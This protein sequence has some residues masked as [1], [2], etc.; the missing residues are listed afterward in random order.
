VILYLPY[1]RTWASHDVVFLAIISPLKIYYSSN[2]QNP[3]VTAIKK[4]LK[5]NIPG[6]GVK[7]QSISDEQK[8]F[9]EFRGDI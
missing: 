4:Q 2:Q 6:L 7:R 5:I 1:E 8:V 3:S 9:K